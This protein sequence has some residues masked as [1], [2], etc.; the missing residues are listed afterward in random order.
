M[1][2]SSNAMQ[3]ESRTKKIIIIII[4]IIVVMIISPRPGN[5]GLMSSGGIV[6]FHGDIDPF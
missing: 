3:T 6:S 5:T 4:I 2:R 1:D